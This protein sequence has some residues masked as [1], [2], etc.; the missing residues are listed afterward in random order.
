MYENSRLAFLASE[1]RE[2]PS[3]A[4]I[5]ALMSHGMWLK[6]VGS[7]SIGLTFFSQ[8]LRYSQAM[9][10]HREPGARWGLGKFEAEIR[11]RIWWSIVAAD[12]QI[13]IAYGIPYAISDKHCDAEKPANIY[14]RDLTADGPTN[15]RPDTEVTEMT[16]SLIQ[17]NLAPVLAEVVDRA[18]SCKV[19]SKQL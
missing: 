19:P 4:S 7:P 11:R 5:M 17:C 1:R 6:L 10:M 9:G 12:K 15:I 14:T 2:Q 13:S 16:I 8:S 3:Y 18:L